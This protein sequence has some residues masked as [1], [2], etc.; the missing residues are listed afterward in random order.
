[1]VIDELVFRLVAEG[2]AKTKAEIEETLKAAQEAQRKLAAMEDK[3]ETKRQR[4][5]A[6]AVKAQEMAFAKAAK[7]QEKLLKTRERMQTKAAAAAKAANA[8]FFSSLEKI[9]GM[10]NRL[11]SVAAIGLTAAIGGSVAAVTDFVKE[12]V[13]LESISHFT[14]MTTQEFQALAYAGEQAGI[15]QEKLADGMRQFNAGFRESVKAGGKGAVA[16]M[17]RDIG[18]NF[19]ELQKLD[20]KT[21]FY[22]VLEQM[23]RLGP[24]FHRA[25]AFAKGFGEIA[26][27]DLARVADVGVK[28]LKEYEQEA[29]DLGLVMTDEMVAAAIELDKNWRRLT[30]TTTGLRNELAMELAPTILE[31]LKH[32]KE[33]VLENKGLLS[34]K[35]KD[36]VHEAVEGGQQFLAWVKEIWPMIRDL[37]KFTA[38]WGK[39]LVIL[40][41]SIKGLLIAQKLTTVINGLG[42]A[43]VSA[44]AGAAGL[45]SMLG[46]G[47]AVFAAFTALLPLALKVGNALGDIGN[48]DTGPGPRSLRQRLLFAETNNGRIKGEEAYAEQIA[49]MSDAEAQKLEDDLVS[50]PRGRLSGVYKPLRSVFQRAREIRD[51]ALTDE[52]QKKV[53]GEAIAEGLQSYS[54]KDLKSLRDQGYISPMQYK[55]EL[56]ARNS[57]AFLNER[58]KDGKKNKQ[59]T[60]AELAK[61]IEQAAKSGANLDELLKGRKI[62][63]GVPPVITIRLFR[64]DIN[65]PITVNG[66]A[67]QSTEQ[68]AQYTRQEFER[69]LGES[70][71]KYSEEILE[72][73]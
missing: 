22:K 6:K 43:F 32:S 27:A 7:E 44:Q 63:G 2:V 36:W 9:D 48:Q 59:V 54:K 67:G 73:R 10:F 24:S 58:P 51:P 46:P 4:E 52:Q 72:A 69:N 39:E 13:R 20:Q 38:E 40:G 62:A 11:A 14:S 29:H 56:G 71:R 35:V 50:T 25:G 31:V 68:L 15:S 23:E 3:A 61:L 8:S 26:G 53:L 57:K 21:I 16:E 42:G 66:R 1:M 17:I 28:K 34:Q 37:A 33:W 47:G 70:L 65:A 5:A 30:A 55:L 12:A 60:D 64:F 45:A 18:L 19:K 49:Q 41:V